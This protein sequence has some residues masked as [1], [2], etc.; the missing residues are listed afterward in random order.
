MKFLFVDDDKHML[1]ALS[2]AFSSN[3]NVAFAECHSVEDAL[4]AI[5]EQKPDVILLDHHLTEDGDEG[6]EIADRVSGVK[7][8]ST[9]TDSFVKD[10]YLKR[11]IE[12]I[13]KSSLKEL[14]DIIAKLSATN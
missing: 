9:T 14:R 5:S 11:G 2:R 4:K 6:F 7:I 8:V 13:N 12:R 3:P 10:E 1:G